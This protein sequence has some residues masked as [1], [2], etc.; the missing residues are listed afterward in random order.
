MPGHRLKFPHILL[1]LLCLSGCGI[2]S[3]AYT[4]PHPLAIMY[5]VS[6][7]SEQGET[8]FCNF[9]V[10]ETHSTAPG[11]VP[12][13]RQR[14]VEAGARYQAADP[15][16]RLQISDG[17][18]SVTFTRV[19]HQVNL[20]GVGAWLPAQESELPEA[21]TLHA[22]EPKEFRL[23]L[24]G[25]DQLLRESVFPK[26]GPPL[27]KDARYELTFSGSNDQ[28]QAEILR[29]SLPLVFERLD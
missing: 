29:L 11:L 3:Q 15:V 13:L 20:G 26:H 17:C 4:L 22:G 10:L 19:K 16:F 12:G 18:E 8:A 1:T 2:F 25:Q 24:L 21:W 9:Q 23:D 7:R 6:Q 14:L 5:F 28:Q 27:V